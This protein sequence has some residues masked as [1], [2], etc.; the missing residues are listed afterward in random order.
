[1][2]GIS[3]YCHNPT[4]LNIALFLEIGTS[5]IHVNYYNKSFEDIIDLL[6]LQHKCAKIFKI[7]RCEYA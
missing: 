1:M 6:R 7:N 4:N 3:I 2:E 5:E